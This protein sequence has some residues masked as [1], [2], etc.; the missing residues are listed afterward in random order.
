MGGFPDDVL[1]KQRPEGGEEWRSELWGYWLREFQAEQV[2]SKK[3]LSWV[4]AWNVQEILQCPILF[5]DYIISACRRHR[6]F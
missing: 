5:F 6:C 4:C 1:F 2:T 3:A